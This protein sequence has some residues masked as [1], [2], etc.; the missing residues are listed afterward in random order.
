VQAIKAL[1]LMIW[2]FQRDY[3]SFRRDCMRIV[4]KF[5]VTVSAMLLVGLSQFASAQEV[6][7]SKKHRVIIPPSSVQLPTGPDG[8][9]M[10]R[11]H[12]RM[13]VPEGA[14]NF[15]HTAAQPNAL[16]P[17]PGFLFNTPASL[18]CVYHLVPNPIPGC[19]PNQTTENPSGGGGAIAIIGAF[20]DPTA[21]SDLQ[22]FSAQF[23]LPAPH[24][25]VVFTQG[26]QP[27]LDPSG[28][29][30]LEEALD[31]E[32]AHAMAP[33]AKLFLIE[34]PNNSLINLFLAATVGANLVAASGGG[35]VSMSFGAL[36]FSQEKSFDSVFT[37]PGVVYFA[38]S[39]DSPGAEYPS[40]S[41][42]VVS[43][44]GTSVARNTTTGNFIAE[45]TWQDAGGGPSQFET[46]PQF[47][48]GIQG[49]VGNVRGT[50]DFSFDADPATGV[51][52]FD[53]NPVFGTGWFVLGGTSVSAPSLA[54]ITNAAGHF[55]ASS[56]AEN[57]ALLQHLLTGT[58]LRDIGLGNCGL[59]AGNFATHGWDFC[60][61][62]GTPQGFAAE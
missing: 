51:W 34:A 43:A 32:W 20:H 13:L 26:T 2:L 42:N 9:V 12:L 4:P 35:E 59:S 14:A 15:G 33:N 54:G 58:G 49:I 50:P 37:T 30:E 57:D 27:G 29:F 36:E 8:D 17:F 6:N 25:T 21:L 46:R 16:P 41:P 56:Q 31:L 23:G 3:S 62:V 44:G 19:N 5:L 47:Q 1:S 52:V 40:T 61:G 22:H 60:T 10:A 38:S 28:G 45:T 24:L 7:S 48:D 53:S 18:G 11:T 39:G 55:R